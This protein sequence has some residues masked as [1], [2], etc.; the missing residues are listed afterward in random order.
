M[1]ICQKKWIYSWL[2]KRTRHT[3]WT[4]IDR[5]MIVKTNEDGCWIEQ[6]IFLI[7]CFLC[8]IEIL[9]AFLMASPDDHTWFY[10]TQIWRLINCLSYS[11]C[12][13]CMP[14]KRTPLCETQSFFVGMC[15]FSLPAAFWPLHSLVFTQGG[16]DTTRWTI[17]SCQSWCF[18]SLYFLLMYLWEGNITA[19]LKATSRWQSCIHRLKTRPQWA[20][21]KSVFLWSFP[22]TND[23]WQRILCRETNQNQILHGIWESRKFHP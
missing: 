15:Q 16:V 17:S 2:P 3:R 6:L 4:T 7:Y 5:N 10:G 13:V 21:H 8:L 18:W 20:W 12:K 23:C 22:T 14:V 19:F 1:L 11:C 9:V